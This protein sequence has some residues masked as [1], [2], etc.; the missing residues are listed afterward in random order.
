MAIGLLGTMVATSFLSGIFGMAGGMILMGILLA[1]LTVPE[2]MALHAVAQMASNGWRGLLWIGHVRWRAVAAY[3]VGCAVALAAWSLVRYVPSKPMALLAL[4]ITPFLVRVLP[5]QLK[6]DPERL[7]H[8]ALYGSACMS[9]ILLT[10]V[11]GPLIDSYFLG[12]TLNRKQ[13][14]ATKALCQIF[15]HGAKLLYFGGL[16]EQAA[17]IDLWLAA[18]VVV[19]SMIGTT[20]ARP[21]LKRLSET[22]YRS[23]AARII[24]LIACTYLAQGAYLMA[25]AGP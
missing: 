9:L 19:A 21:V 25:Q 6:P 8:G 18:A 11:A 7:T 2:A 12:G 23:W 22:Q 15:G 3:L 1:L 24:A 20:I 16:V 10:G 13:I 4:G 17:S 5:A 14:I